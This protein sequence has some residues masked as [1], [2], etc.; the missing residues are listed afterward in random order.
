MSHNIPAK[1]PFDFFTRIS[2]YL[3]VLS[4]IA[5]A[6][7]VNLWRVRVGFGIGIPLPLNICGLVFGIRAYK[8][9]GKNTDK[10]E[11]NIILLVNSL[12]AMFISFVISYFGIL[13][14]LAYFGRS[15]IKLIK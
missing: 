4:L 13:I 6:I 11:G 7:C 15:I 9:I 2:I 12:H 3:F 14:F 1:Q 8:R 5:L 10:T